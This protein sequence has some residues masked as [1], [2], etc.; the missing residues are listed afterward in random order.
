MKI[1]IASAIIS[2]LLAVLDGEHGVTAFVDPAVIL[3]ILVANASVGVITETNAEKA[4]G[5]LKAY[6]ADVATVVRSGEDPD[7]HPSL[8]S[9]SAL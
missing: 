7:R 6:A 9:S 1:L 3:L 5:E 2:F 4:I 8:P